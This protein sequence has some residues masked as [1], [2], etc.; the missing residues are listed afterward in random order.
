MHVT[1]TK[2]KVAAMRATDPSR[3]SNSMARELG[4]TPEAVRQHLVTLGLPTVTAK[5]F[6][7]R[8]PC[9]FPPTLRTGR[10]GAFSELLVCADLTARGWDV[11]R[12]QTP[13]A[14]FDLVGY[15][16]DRLWRVEVKGRRRPRNGRKPHWPAAGRFDLLAMVDRGAR[17]IIYKPALDQAA[18]PDPL[19]EA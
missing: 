17:T 3:T 19:C 10:L 5:S 9:R 6:K 14:P 13:D 12:A 1:D 18:E 2:R 11:Y 15:F 16:G 4:M 7:D 8:E